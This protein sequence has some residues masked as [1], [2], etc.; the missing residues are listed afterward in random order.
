MLL[1]RAE[2]AKQLTNPIWPSNSGLEAEELEL[3]Y[4]VAKTMGIFS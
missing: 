2:T 4:A 1:S 3:S